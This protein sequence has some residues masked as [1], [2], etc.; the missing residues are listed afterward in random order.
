M[1]CYEVCGVVSGNKKADGTPYTFI[2]YLMPLNHGSG[3]KGNMFYLNKYVDVHVGDM[4]TPI[5]N[6]SEAGK[7][8]L[9][10][11]NVITE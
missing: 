2:H 8:Y 9:V 6:V 11:I 3:V 1:A 5:Y 4:I 10:D 7:P